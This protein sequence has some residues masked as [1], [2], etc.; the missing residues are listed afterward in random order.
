M[1]E[2]IPSQAD[3]SLLTTKTPVRPERLESQIPLDE[4]Y[5]THVPARFTRGAAHDRHCEGDGPV[6]VEQAGE[7]LTVSCATDHNL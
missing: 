1:Q 3:F 2:G 5:P 6:Q 4:V 7:H